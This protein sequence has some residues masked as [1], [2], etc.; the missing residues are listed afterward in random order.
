VLLLAAVLVLA[1]VVAGR[2]TPLPSGIPA[3]GS[4]ASDAAAT[5]TPSAVASALVA[6]APST[7]PDDRPTP[8][9]ATPTT[10]LD[11]VAAAV[12]VLQGRLGW[13]CAVLVRVADEP[14]ADGLVRKLAATEH[15]DGFVPGVLGPIWAG[16][17]PDA[18]ARAFKGRL[19]SLDAVGLDWIVRGADSRVSAV[20]LLSQGVPGGT[21]L[22]RTG[23]VLW[24]VDCRT[25]VTDVKSLLADGRAADW[26]VTGEVVD[27]GVV[28]LP[29]DP[30][31]RPR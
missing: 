10:A 18:A 27:V 21:R 20:R 31:S 8:S 6:P 26:P 30:P 16:D 29:A 25:A 12:R 28:R 4:S 17:D 1:V 23:D 19:L 13:P 22:W 2:W 9:A 14:L 5:A 11:P 15:L 7:G 24:P 3:V